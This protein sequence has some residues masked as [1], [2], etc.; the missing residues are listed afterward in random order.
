MQAEPFTGSRF[1]NAWL[2]KIALSYS[3]EGE[4]SQACSEAALKV[5]THESFLCSLISPSHLSGKIHYCNVVSE[6]T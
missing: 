5:N 4:Q 2:L 6:D 1:K 3:K